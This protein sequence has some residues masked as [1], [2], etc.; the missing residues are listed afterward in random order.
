MR[1]GWVN[2]LTATGVCSNA[3]IVQIIHAVVQNVVTSQ[4]LK[5][6]NNFPQIT[7]EMIMTSCMTH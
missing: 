7:V 5:E 1:E 3:I 2:N 4:D 6:K